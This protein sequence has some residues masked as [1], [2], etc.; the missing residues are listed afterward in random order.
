MAV[1]SGSSRLHL[2]ARYA[3]DVQ[4]HAC[5]R[6]HTYIHTYTRARAH[7]VYLGAIGMEWCRRTVESCELAGK[8]R[9]KRRTFDA[10]EAHRFAADVY[11]EMAFNGLKSAVR[12]A[13]VRELDN[14]RSELDFCAFALFFLSFFPVFFFPI[15]FFSPLLP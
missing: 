5:T 12:I 8:W 4:A 2:G 14:G 1:R 10:S 15:F 6:V 3:S 7:S 9:P 13:N 11:K